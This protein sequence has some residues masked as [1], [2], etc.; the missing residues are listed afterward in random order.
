MA[1]THYVIVPFAGFFT[2]AVDSEKELNTKEAYQLAIEQLNDSEIMMTN[3]DGNTEVEWDYY[4]NICQGNVFH[5]T[6]NSTRI[7]EII[8]DSDE[9]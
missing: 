8:D 1:K 3:I 9:D 5:P 4:E 6:V 7:D 2:V